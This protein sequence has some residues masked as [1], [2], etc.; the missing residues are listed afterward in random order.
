MRLLFMLLLVSTGI[1]AQKNYEFKNGNWYNGSGF[2]P[3]V[4]YTVGGVFSAKAPSRI[5]SVI[6][7]NNYYVIPPLGD[8]YSASLAG[9]PLPESIIRSYLSEGVFYLQIL[10]NTKEQQEKL[11]PQLPSTFDVAYAQG[12]ITGNMGTPYLKYEA[13]ALGIAPGM[14]STK[15]DVLKDSRKSSGNGYWFVD[16]K[17]TLTANWPAIMARKPHAISIWMPDAEVSGGKEGKGLTPEMVKAVV[18]KAHKAKLKVYA[19]V[20][21]AADVRLAVNYGADAVVGLPGTEWDGKGDKSRYVLSDGDISKL[22]KK[23]TVI[24]PLAIKGY[25]VGD[26]VSRHILSTMNRLLTAGANLAIGS[27]DPQR[28]IRSELNTW[29]MNRLN[30]QALLKILCQRTPQA[31][32]PN[33]KIGKI[34]SGYE[35]SFLVVEHDPL[36][37]LLRIRS[38]IMKVKKGELLK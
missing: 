34:E 38:S 7:L 4:W 23:K 33:R 11:Q 32:F 2:T 8:A 15:M 20:E 10:G 6:D 18:K 28:T 21:T 25:V 31:I 5:D 37:N 13:D 9:N 36:T 24:I 35:A 12:E 29:Y 30:T 26:S 22:V 17:E 27:G 19:H 3:G 1:F 16:S 14:I